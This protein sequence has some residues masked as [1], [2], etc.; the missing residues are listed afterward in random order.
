M[1]SLRLWIGRIDGNAFLPVDQDCPEPFFNSLESADSIFVGFGGNILAGI[2][3]PVFLFA[4][5]RNV[6]FGHNLFDC[7]PG[8]EDGPGRLAVGIGQRI[9]FR[10]MV[11]LVDDFV[12]EGRH[13]APVR[14]FCYDKCK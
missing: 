7:L 8:L 13:F 5:P 14:I 2:H 1:V 9:R 6:Y 11:F 12:I 4:L 10:R 3:E